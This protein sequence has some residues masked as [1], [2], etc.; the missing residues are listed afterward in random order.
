MSENPGKYGALLNKAKQSAK[1]ENQKEVKPEKMVNVGAKVPQ[2]YRNHWAAEAKR[3]GRSM[4]DV[5]TSAL[6]AAFGLPPEV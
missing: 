2:S 5:M 6:I 4:T 3:S 1:P